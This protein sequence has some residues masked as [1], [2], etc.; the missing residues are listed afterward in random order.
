MST[1]SS[2]SFLSC[3]LLI[4]SAIMLVASFHSIAAAS[5]QFH[6]VN[7]AVYFIQGKRQTLQPNQA[8][9]I[10]KHCA[11]LASIHG[12]LV[13]TEALIAELK[14]RLTV[15]LCY[16]VSLHAD[17]K[18]DT[19]VVLL[20]HAYPELKWITPIPISSDALKQAYQAQLALFEQ[21]TELSQQRIASLDEAQQPV[22]QEKLALAKARIA[23][24]KQL[25]T[26]APASSTITQNSATLNLGEINVELAPLVGFSGNDLSLYLPDVKGLIAGYSVDQV[27]LAHL[28]HWPKWQQAIRHFSRYSLD[29]VLPASDK[30]YK[31]DMLAVPAQFFSLLPL[32][33]PQQV[34]IKLATLY[35]DKQ[36]QQRAIMQW[37]HFQQQTNFE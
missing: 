11:L 22:W 33:D 30:P 2:K 28:A 29:W 17:I 7:D 10:G 37:H 31:P 15:P 18:Q 13:T 27:P 21:S 24:W 3:T 19:S 20:K 32:Q 9:V 6:K 14:Q 4:W 12:D 1:R 8:V 34:A 23:T 35:P 36:M 25:A 5:H 16:A 26:L